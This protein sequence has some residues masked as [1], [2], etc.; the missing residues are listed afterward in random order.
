LFGYSEKKLA[1]DIGRIAKRL[2]SG[3]SST[4]DPQSRSVDLH[5]VSDGEAAPYN[6]YLGNLYLKLKDMTRAQRSESIE[7]FLSEVLFPKE[8]T[9]DELIAALALRARTRFELELRRNLM[10]IGGAPFE[11]VAYGDGDLLL[12]LV[13][14]GDESIMSVSPDKLSEASISADDAYKTA[15]ATLVR[16]TSENQWMKVSEHVWASTYEDDYDFSRLV[17]AGSSARFPFDGLPVVFSPSHSVCL[18]TDTPTGAALAEMAEIGNKAA[19]S[20]RPFSQLFWTLLPDGTW[21]RWTTN[22]GEDGHAE[23]VLQEVRERIAQYDDQQQYLESL[24]QERGED[25][26]VA[27][28]QVYERGGELQSVA[29][30]TLNL[31]SYLPGTDIVALV[32]PDAGNKEPVLGAVTWAQFAEALGSDTLKMMDDLSP[33]RFQLL[34]ELTQ[35][36]LQRLQ[37]ALQPV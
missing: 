21:S 1:K 24:L 27:S 7:A 20:H 12:E 25:S 30:Y 6:I 36:Q 9:A 33:P 15:A 35:E 11:T 19:E 34:D 14:D 8:L 28:Y 16:A 37:D 32:D 13:A 4:Y 17:A 5:R 29:T 18:A 22:P 10:A 23:L 3:L 31:P 26:F 2:D